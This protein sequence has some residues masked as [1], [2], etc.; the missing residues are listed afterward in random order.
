MFKAFVHEGQLQIL[1]PGG[2]LHEFALFV[3][4]LSLADM[5]ITW[6]YSMNISIN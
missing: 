2:E 1:S 5:G 4:S 6:Y 3:L